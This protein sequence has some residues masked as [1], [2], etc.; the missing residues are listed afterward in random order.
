MNNLRNKSM[1]AA[2][3]KLQQNYEKNNRV[4]DKY[5]VDTNLLN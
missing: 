3:L 4:V 1:L 2:Q 5:I